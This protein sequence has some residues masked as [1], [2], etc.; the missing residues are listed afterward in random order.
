MLLI[1]VFKRFIFS[2][3]LQIF[4]DGE[5]LASKGVGR[6]RL[7]NMENLTDVTLDVYITH[8]VAAP[9]DGHGYDNK[10]Y[11]VKQVHQ[12]V[13]EILKESTADAIILGGDFNAGPE[14][15]EGNFF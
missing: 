5:C 14:F 7:A 10:Y 11:R 13:D 8:T 9:P 3:F 15:E 1:L 2:Y 4:I 12:L 6:I